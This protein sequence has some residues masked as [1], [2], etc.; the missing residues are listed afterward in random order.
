MFSHFTTLCMK[1]LKIDWNGRV[2][3]ITHLSGLK[4]LFPENQLLSEED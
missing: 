1:G 2:N 3:V 4:E